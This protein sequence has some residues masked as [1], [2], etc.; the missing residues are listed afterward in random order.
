M[1]NKPGLKKRNFINAKQ[2]L[3]VVHTSPMALAIKKT[4]SKLKLN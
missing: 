4:Q 2:G 1:A 3:N